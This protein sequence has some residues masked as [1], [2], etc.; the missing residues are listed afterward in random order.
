[1]GEREDKR[2]LLRDAMDNKETYRVPMGF[3]HH[4]VLGKDQF[5]G[6]EDPAI[7]ERIIEGHKRY[8]EE[9][10]PDMMKFM[11][12]GFMGYPPVM[13]NALRTGEDLLRIRS[14]GPEHPWITEQL[15]YVKRLQE[16]FG[17]KVMTFYNIFAP[18]Q[19]I[20]IR[21]DFYD[22]DYERFAAL[23]ESF[24]EELHAAGMEIQKDIKLLVSRLLTE[25]GLDGIYY[26]VQNIQSKRYT[27]EMYE[28]IVRP[29]EIEV[30]ES[31]NQFSDYNILHIC[32][33]AH[34]T[35]Q[36][37]FYQDYEAKA[38]NWATFTEGISIEEGRKLFPGKCVL[39]GFD[40]NPETLIDSGSREEICTF[41]NRL[42]REN[43]HR[44]YIMGAD[45]SIPNEIKDGRIHW[46]A[47]Q[48]QE[49][50]NR[51]GKGATE[52]KKEKRSKRENG[53][54]E[55]NRINEENSIS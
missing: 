41:V 50:E 8:F 2:K 52:S 15:K 20:R 40:N 10:E 36:L 5:R 27:R 38:Y 26:C 39:G 42:I 32:G 29:T 16:L 11:S 33:Y 45:C 6:L 53:I 55:G 23:A 13:D 25:T 19:V 44:G 14:I 46:I 1:M 54:K 28:R 31:A 3:W 4:F 37:C 48:L 34:H 43:G 7:I 30:L 35:N 9:V 21:L 49:K 22:K 51:I 47:R 12:E 18:L 17:D 24:P